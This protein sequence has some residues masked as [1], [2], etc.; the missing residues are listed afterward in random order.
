MKTLVTGGNGFIGSRLVRRLASSGEH[1]HVLDLQ[2]DNQPSN[3]NGNVTYFSGSILDARSVE[4]AMRGCD[5]VYHLAGYARNWALDK[6]TFF[7]INVGG[8]EMVLV[9]AY[10]LGIE[11]VVH[12]SSNLTIGSSLGHSADETTVRESGCFTPYE[13]SKLESERVVRDFV[14]KGLDCVI[15]NPARV[16][17]PGFLNESNS[18]TRMIVWY[19]EGTWRL[20]LG[21]G[22]AIGN[23]V[24]IDD[25]LQGYRLAMER[26]RAGERYILGGENVSFSQFFQQLTAVSQIRHR[27][28]HLPSTLALAFAAEEQTRAKIFG[29]YPIITLGWTKTFLADWNQTS[30]KA[31]RELGYSITPLDEALRKTICWIHST[32]K[33][34]PVG[35]P[36]YAFGPNFET[37]RSAS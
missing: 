13:Q 16:F 32:A 4:L 5:R 18:V 26:G 28:F 6:R 11:R 3:S 12:T 36:S 17:G 7:D 29:A 31:E 33:V 14:R 35:D 19:L 20:I 22:S 23:Y 21:N 30:A 25:L 10:R 8:T 2:S 9:T 1:V 15:V 34:K 37:E 24:F 27:M